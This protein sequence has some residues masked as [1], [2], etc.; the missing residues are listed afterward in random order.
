M[1][2]IGFGSLNARRAWPPARSES[3]SPT[4]T[5]I[6]KPELLLD[7]RPLAALVLDRQWSPGGLVVSV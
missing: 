6:V 5:R 4:L 2:Y 1:K 3:W 7:P